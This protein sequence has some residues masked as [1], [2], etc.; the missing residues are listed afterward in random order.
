MVE[1]WAGHLFQTP[2]AH[3]PVLCQKCPQTRMSISGLVV[4]YIVAI[5][6]TWVRLLADAHGFGLLA[7]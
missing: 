4:D 2:M 1:C 6:V 7:G 3:G 5:D